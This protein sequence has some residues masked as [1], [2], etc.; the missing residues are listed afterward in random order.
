MGRK[1]ERKEGRESRW[2]H[3]KDRDGLVANREATNGCL[4]PPIIHPEK[5][6]VR[7]AVG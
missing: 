2:K 3:T 4:G 5:A 7:H 6:Q 1:G